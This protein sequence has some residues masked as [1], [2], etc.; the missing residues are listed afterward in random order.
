MIGADWIALGALG[1]T[2]LGMAGKYIKDKNRDAQEL[3]S[4]KARID[5][6]EKQEDKMFDMDLLTERAHERMADSCRA[7]IYRDMNRMEKTVK[8]LITRLV[9]LEERREAKEEKTDQRLVEI[10]NSIVEIKTILKSIGRESST[11]HIGVY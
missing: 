11:K 9:T 6:I 8:D 2:V 1:F 3:G 7:E 4:L 10:S 5:N